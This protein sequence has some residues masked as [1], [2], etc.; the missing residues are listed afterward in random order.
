MEKKYSLFNKEFFWY[1]VRIARRNRLLDLAYIM[2]DSWLHKKKLIH[3]KVESIEQYCEIHLDDKI[4]EIEPSQYRPVYEAPYFELSEGKEYQFRSPSI[5]V[6]FLHNVNAIGATGWVLTD[7]GLLCDALKY[8]VDHRIDFRSGPIKRTENDKAWVEVNQNTLELERAI[9]LC[10]T[11]AVNY[12]HF[13]VEILSRLGYVNQLEEADGIP[14]LV[15]EEVRMYSQLEQLLKVINSNREVIYVP[16]GIRIRAKLLI[17]PSMNTWMPFNVKSREM[18]QISDNLVAKSGLENIRLHA[19]QYI[20]K[21]TMKK[22]F[23]S[24]TKSNAL[25]VANESAITRIFSAAGFE[26]VF[27]ETLSYIEQIE[28]FS[29]VKCIVGASGAALTNILYCHPGTVVGCIV[30][31]EYDFCIYSTMAYLLGCNLLFANPDIIYRGTCIGEDKY[32]MSE[33]QCEKYIE[34]ILKMCM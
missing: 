22:I 32:E 2:L 29:T 8:D 1:C 34:E 27:A 23:I 13:T 17:Q 25:R 18:F 3:M 14:I 21:Q 6:A 26:I 5:Y 12:Y 7:E 16:S 24:R 15:D 31:K 20:K 28:L 10:G 4:I 19:E 11:A 9:N 33:K 30:P